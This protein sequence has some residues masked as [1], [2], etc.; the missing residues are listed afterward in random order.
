MKDRTAPGPI[1]KISCPLWSM[2][3]IIIHV[4]LTR[5]SSLQL[6]TAKLFAYAELMKS[7]FNKISEVFPIFNNMT[8][9]SRFSVEIKIFNSKLLIQNRRSYFRN[10]F[11]AEYHRTNIFVNYAKQ[12][13]S[14][15]SSVSIWQW[16]V[17]DISSLITGDSNVGDFMMV[18]YKK[19]S[20][21]KIF[22][23]L[24]TKSSFNI[25]H[26]QRWYRLYQS[27]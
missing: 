15:R 3:S 27:C 20:I 13:D 7:E 21:I 2:I 1:S 5:E 11:I 10:R 18:E 17:L 24:P 12:T 22:N 26:Q 8:S 4:K 23:W 6:G 19:K 25:R 14:H 16:T 9:F